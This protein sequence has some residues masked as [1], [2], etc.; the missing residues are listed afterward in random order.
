MKI[1]YMISTH[2]HGRGGHF[3]DMKVIANAMNRTNDNLV[4]EV[5]WLDGVCDPGETATITVDL[6]NSGSAYFNYYP[7]AVIY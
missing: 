6:I 7:G 2:G 1:L 3:Y 5:V 4:F